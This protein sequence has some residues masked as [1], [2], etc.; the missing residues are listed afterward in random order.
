M[1]NEKL[2]IKKLERK[3][4][5]FFQQFTDYIFTQRY[6]QQKFIVHLLH[7]K[8]FLGTWEIYNQTPQIHTNQTQILSL[9]GAYI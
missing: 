2:P 4:Y 3:Q 7:S 6:I 8:C 5:K 9:C 1:H